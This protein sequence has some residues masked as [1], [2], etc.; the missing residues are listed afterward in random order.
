MSDGSSLANQLRIIEDELRLPL[1]M[2]E[3]LG[4]LWVAALCAAW[5]DTDERLE[6]QHGHRLDY[7][8]RN[9][10]TRVPYATK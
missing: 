3:G 8:P 7:Q 6:H 4:P 9:Q 1:G 10:Y 5:L 2:T